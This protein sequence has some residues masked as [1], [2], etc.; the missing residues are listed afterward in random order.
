MVQ[1]VV[2]TIAMIDM[3]LNA[4]ILQRLLSTEANFRPMWLLYQQRTLSGQKIVTQ[5]SL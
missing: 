3:C 2:L 5:H 1:G 4:K